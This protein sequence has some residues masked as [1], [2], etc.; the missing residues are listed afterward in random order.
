M[1]DDAQQIAVVGRLI[2]E[3]QTL[4]ATSFVVVDEFSDPVDEA[5]SRAEPRNRHERRKQAALRRKM[6]P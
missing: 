5:L 4:A 3:R 1:M 2:S 6:Y